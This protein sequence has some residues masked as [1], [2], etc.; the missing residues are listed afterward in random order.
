MLR[1]KFFYLWRVVCCCL[2]IESAPGF[3]GTLFFIFLFSDS[4]CLLTYLMAA[5]CKSIGASHWT[6]VD[7][8]MQPPAVF[9]TGRGCP[10]SRNG[11]VATVL[12]WNI[13]WVSEALEFFRKCSKLR[14]PDGNGNWKAWH[15]W[16]FPSPGT[17]MSFHAIWE[18]LDIAVKCNDLRKLI[19]LHLY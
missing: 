9:L 5:T 7:G 19:F 8:N 18:I 3:C 16:K 13:S 14:G 11:A 2:V 4:F 10:F 6:T 17:Y 15:P 12:G 1:E